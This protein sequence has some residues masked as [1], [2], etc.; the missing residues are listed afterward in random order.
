MVCCK[1]RTV[2]LAP[3]LHVCLYNIL[4]LLMEIESSIYDV[5]QFIFAFKVC[6]IQVLNHILNFNIFVPMHD[7]LTAC[8]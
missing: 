8:Q 4:D 2:V 5:R 3:Q 6:K 1:I 7:I